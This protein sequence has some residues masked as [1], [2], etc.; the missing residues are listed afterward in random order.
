MATTGRLQWAEI[1][2][3]GV[4]GLAL[5]RSSQAALLSATDVATASNLTYPTIYEEE[6]NVHVALRPGS[7]RTISSFKIEARQPTYPIG[8]D[9]TEPGKFPPPGNDPVYH[10]SNPGTFQLYDDG[11]TVVNAVREPTFWRPTAM[12]VSAVN[13]AGAVITQP[14]IHYI[15][16]YRKIDG[17]SSWPQAAVIYTDSNMRLKPQPQLGRSDQAFGS[18]I[19]VGPAEDAKRPVA[20]IRSLKYLAA[21]NS[22]RVEYLNGGSAILQLEAINRQVTR[23]GVT[24]DYDDDAFARFRSMFVSNGDSD[25]DHVRWL[26]PA[27]TVHNDPILTYAGSAATE[28]L[29]TRD[30]WSIHNTSAPDIW[31]GNFV[32]V[33]EPWVLWAVIPVLLLGRRRLS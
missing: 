27:G 18:S 15:Q 7:G 13:K 14:S 9:H 8:V 24:V 32:V 17:A 11:I 6:D 2:L 25:V 12:S 5:P 19:I 10:F 1:V 28:F 21:S 33:P 31:V 30:H 22:L 4:A 26:D 23:V 16:L 3:A 29:F 20:D